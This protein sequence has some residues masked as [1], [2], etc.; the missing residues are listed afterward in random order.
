[1][2]WNVVENLECG[3]GNLQTNCII[4][5][6]KH[7]SCSVAFDVSNMNQEPKFLADEFIVRKV[8]ILM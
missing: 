8:V 3:V 1:M 4:L 2:N 7:V 6:T 5:D